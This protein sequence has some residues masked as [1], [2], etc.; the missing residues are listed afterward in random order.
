MI[1]R[2]ED[3]HILRAIIHKTNRKF[4]IFIAIAIILTQVPILGN[5]VRIINTLVHES[6]HAFIGLLGGD[7]LEISLFANTEGLTYTTTSSWVWGF[8]T[9][10]A[11]YLFSS[12]IA[13]LS[14]WLIAKEKNTILIIILLSFIGLNLLFWVRNAY[15]VFWLASFGAGFLWML[16]KGGTTVVRNV[17]ILIASILLVESITST[18]EIMLLSFIQP[19]SAGDA[20]SL[21]KATVIIPVQIWGVFFFVQAIWFCI[22]SLRLGIYKVKS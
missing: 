19:Y 10:G 17:L 5:Y 1:K 16:Y 14:F 18:F 2:N 6:G 21:A 13:F 9:S 22:V 12:F 20:T 11:G 8:L 3:E 7:V 4:F 15:G